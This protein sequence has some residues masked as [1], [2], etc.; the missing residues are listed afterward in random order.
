MHSIF[1]QTQTQTLNW[2]E[3]SFKWKY[4]PQTI[5][6]N[7]WDREEA[8]LAYSSAT[9]LGSSKYLRCIAISGWRKIAWNK[10]NQSIRIDSSC[11]KWQDSW[12]YSSNNTNSIF[13]TAKAI[14]SRIHIVCINK[15]EVDYWRVTNGIK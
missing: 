3:I 11:T 4:L 7:R 8:T 5:L 1:T 6:L 15:L 9:R 13:K 10:C 14:S 2:S 12:N